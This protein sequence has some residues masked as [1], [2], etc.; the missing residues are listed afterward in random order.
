M[1]LDTFPY[2]GGTTTCEALWMGVPTL[3]LS[4][5]RMLAR[6]GVGMLSCVGLEDW[7]ADNEADYF[8]K[9]IAHAADF[10]NLATLRNTL[11]GGALASAL[12]DAARFSRHLERAFREMWQLHTRG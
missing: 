9:A 11:R 12:F 8:A 4:G 3:T 10:N 2:S 5:D 7:I 1:V 6:Q